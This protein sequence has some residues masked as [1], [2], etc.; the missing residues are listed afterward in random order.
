MRAAYEHAGQNTGS[1]TFLQDTHSHS[2]AETCA[3]DV[4]DAT[5]FHEGMLRMQSHELPISKMI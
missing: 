4:K 3:L 5:W 2:S 1:D